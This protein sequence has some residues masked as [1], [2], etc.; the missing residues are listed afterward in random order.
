MGLF[1]RQK[2]G[3][4]IVYTNFMMLKKI[5]VLL[6]GEIKLS[7]IHWSESLFL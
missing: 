3:C 4:L 2:N 6:M 1:V 5:V 7:K